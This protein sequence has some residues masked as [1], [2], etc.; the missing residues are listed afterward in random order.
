[1]NFNFWGQ[2]IMNN[3]TNS[4]RDGWTNFG[5]VVFH[6]YN[7]DCGEGFL[8]GKLVDGVGIC[9]KLLLPD[10]SCNRITKGS[11]MIYNTKFNAKAEGELYLNIPQ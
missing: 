10:G 2:K 11:Y 4:D 6:Y 8:L 3:H 9:Y 5:T 1:M 7:M